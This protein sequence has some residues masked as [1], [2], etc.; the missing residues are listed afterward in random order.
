MDVSPH[1]KFN[2]LMG[3]FQIHYSDVSDLHHE[4]CKSAT[5]M[6]EFGSCQANG[7]Y[8]KWT[9]LRNGDLRERAANGEVTVLNIELG[10]VAGLFERA[11]KLKRMKKG[12]CFCIPMREISFGDLSFQWS[13]EDNEV[14]SPLT[15]LFDDLIAL[16]RVMNLVMLP[17]S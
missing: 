4:P 17:E 3:A 5:D 14:P 9:L 13:P 15:R 2:T 6:I 8:R 11:R 12:N 10:K 7:R 1:T 16:E